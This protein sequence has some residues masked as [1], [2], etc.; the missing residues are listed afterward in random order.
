[1][2]DV[3]VKVAYFVIEV[4]WSMQ[5]LIEFPAAHQMH[6]L[7]YQINFLAFALKLMMPHAA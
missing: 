5:L 7:Q 2:H 4:V 6:F 1:M 3:T